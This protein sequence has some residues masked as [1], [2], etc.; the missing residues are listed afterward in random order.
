MGDLLAFDSL[1]RRVDTAIEGGVSDVEVKNLF[2]SPESLAKLNR[3]ITGGLGT[4]R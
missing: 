4:I 1:Q 2:A 3:D